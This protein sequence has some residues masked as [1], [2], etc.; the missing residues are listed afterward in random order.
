M[1]VDI[2][3]DVG[4][5]VVRSVGSVAWRRSARS[6]ASAAPAALEGRDGSNSGGGMYGWRLRDHAGL[7]PPFAE[8][9]WLGRRPSDKRRSNSCHGMPE[10]VN[11]TPEEYEQVFDT[12]RMSAHP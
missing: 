7:S 10:L 3:D 8:S 2:D 12:F 4:S 11:P 9:G 6:V 5:V 1:G